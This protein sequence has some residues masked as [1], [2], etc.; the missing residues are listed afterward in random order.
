[1]FC[2]EGHHRWGCCKEYSTDTVNGCKI[3]L[4]SFS[5][6][7]E[8]GYYRRRGLREDELVKCLYTWLLSNCEPLPLNHL[9]E[10]F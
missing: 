4:T 9:A 1:M 5:C 10:Q 8:V 6:V 3:E 7:Q 2:L